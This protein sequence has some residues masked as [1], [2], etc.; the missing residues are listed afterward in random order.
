MEGSHGDRSQA[1]LAPS[2]RDRRHAPRHLRSK[3]NRLLGLAA[4]LIFFL[5]PWIPG[6]HPET[7][8]EALESSARALASVEE[9]KKAIAAVD[10][11][12]GVKEKLELLIG[13]GFQRLLA[14]SLLGVALASLGLVLVPRFARHEAIVG[15]G[16]AIAIAW[17]GLG[18]A[19]G[20]DLEPKPA[21]PIVALWLAAP[22][23]FTVAALVRTLKGRGLHLSRALALLAIGLPVLPTAVHWGARLDCMLLGSTLWLDVWRP[24]SLFGLRSPCGRSRRSSRTRRSVTS[25][26]SSGS[27]RRTHPE[28]RSSPPV[29]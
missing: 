5:A 23:V 3:L 8:F 9:Q 10:A 27:T 15:T 11:A 19:W 1:L 25:R 24:T 22:V 13:E 4:L 28:T 17:L 20:K 26:P 16:C 2:P 18:V 29:T 21:E 14:G 7:G 6:C 12:P